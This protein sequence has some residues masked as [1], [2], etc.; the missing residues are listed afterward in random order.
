[1]VMPSRYEPFGMVALEAAACGAAVIASQIGGLE[2]IVTRSAGAIAGVPPQQ[3]ERLAKTLTDLLSDPGR[4][5]EMGKMAQAYVRQAYTWTQTADRIA[6][7]LS[8][9]TGNAPRRF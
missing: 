4:M 7:I 3:P 6:S 9:L 8:A 1:V 2:E 5:R